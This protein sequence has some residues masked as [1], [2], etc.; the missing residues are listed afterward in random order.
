[1]SSTLP[2]TV[3]LVVVGAGTAGA[4]TA[5][6][7][8][9]RGLRV[10]CVDRRPLD[11]AGARWVNGVTRT[12][13]AEAG[14]DEVPT[15]G[16]PPPFHLIAPHQRVVVPH[17]DVVDVDMRALVARL[18]ERA[19]AAGAILVGDVAVRGR[20]G[21]M[22]RTEAG[23]VRARWLVDASGLVGVGLLEQ[24]PVGAEHLCAAAQAVFE[25]RDRAGAEAY[26]AAVG[27][28]PREVCAHVGVAGGYSV[29]NVRL[30][31]HGDT[32]GVL[33]GS[34]PALG[35][36][37][38]KAVLNDFVRAQPWIGARIYGGSG[39]IP[40]RRPRD[41]LTDGTVALVGDAG[42][43][44]FPAHGSGIDAGILAG[45]LLADT[46]GAGGTLF[47][48]EAAWQRRW[49]GLFATYDAVRRW[50]QTLD[51]D[52][53]DEVIELGLFDVEMA[54]AGLDQQLPR[55]NALRLRSKAR[56]LAANRSWAR[57]LADLAARAVAVQALYAQ[58]PRN[59]VA[60][61]AWASAVQRVLPV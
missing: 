5:A 50:N 22:L 36:R 12:A 17:H 59:P 2:E 13:L 20:D 38:G 28:P 33:T 53:L 54:R 8:A 18:H 3:D 47:D 27:V 16:P 25:V 46:L 40:I 29:Q 6:F 44:V 42:C 41:R 11:G 37:S 39:A 45:K 34:I 43:Q 56:T 51:A 60:R 14:L 31:D 30:H 21:S 58:Y 32:V 23:D 57:S 61:A 49:G 48:Y 1:M 55:V 35:V 24:S 52:A 7:A 26:F 15:L 4:A 19:R 9:A 10:L